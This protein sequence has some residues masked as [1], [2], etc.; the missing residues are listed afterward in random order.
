MTSSF[1][2]TDAIELAIIGAFSS[3]CPNP[4]AVTVDTDLESL[5]DSVGLVIALAEAQSA[6]DIELAPDEII[7]VI[8]CRTLGEVARVFRSA[9]QTAYS[10]S[11]S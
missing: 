7:Q 11:A 2:D 1:A 4:E 10:A 3:T 8:Q 5:V 9:L 6:L